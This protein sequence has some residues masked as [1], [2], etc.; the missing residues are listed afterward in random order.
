MS[1]ET[2]SGILPL[3]LIVLVFW[4]LVI[5]PAR[6]RQHDMGKVQS[7]VRAGSQ[8]MLSSG[9]FGT[10]VSVAD[11][12]VQVE[13]APGTAVKVARQAVARVLDDADGQSDPQRAVDEQE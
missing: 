7:S 13:L 10:V 8:V 11:E 12:T 9:L 2:L 3:L 5:R 1:S 4:F 6:K